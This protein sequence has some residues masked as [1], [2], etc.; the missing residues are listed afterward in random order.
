MLMD[1]KFGQVSRMFIRS[2]S[3]WGLY[4]LMYLIVKPINLVV[5][6]LEVSRVDVMKLCNNSTAKHR[7]MNSHRREKLI[8]SHSALAGCLSKFY[9]SFYHK[10]VVRQGESSAPPNS[11]ELQSLKANVY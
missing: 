2:V 1:K 4:P 8:S 11:L 6:E 9:K 7:E 5:V 10:V 3:A